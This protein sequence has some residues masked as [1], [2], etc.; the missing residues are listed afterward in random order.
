MFRQLSNN[1]SDHNSINSVYVPKTHYY[2]TA[3]EINCIPELKILGH[4]FLKEIITV[5]IRPQQMAI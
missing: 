2:G 1:K 3:H 5:E 4:Q